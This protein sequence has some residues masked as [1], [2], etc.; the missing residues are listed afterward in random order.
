VAHHEDPAAWAE[1]LRRFHEERS[2]ITEALL[3]RCRDGEVDPYLWCAAAIDPP[4]G[5]VVDLACGSGPL[6]DHVAGWMGLDRSRP[7]LAVAHEARRGPLV[8]ASAVHAPFR[9]GSAGAVTCSMGFQVIDPLEAALAEVARLLP[10]G[11]R[12]VLLL[13]SRGPLSPRS[14]VTYLWL[15]VVLRQR[16]RYPNDAALHRSQLGPLADRHGLEVL[17]DERRR[18]RMPVDSADVVA[19][20]VRSL[21][22]P[23]GDPDRQRRAR[24]ARS[25][26]IGR[27][28]DVPLR[29]VVLRRRGAPPPAGSDQA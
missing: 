22:L 28:L 7:E 1:Y 14:A 11:G 12:A 6:A 24:R 16:I 29:R 19:L 8:C 17:T 10:P 25:W 20:L 2:G 23:G 13:P 3:R 21:Y 5:P 4:D 9:Q 18:F 27:H 26:R 15:Q